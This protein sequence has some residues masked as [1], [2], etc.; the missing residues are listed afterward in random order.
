MF[1]ELLW[2]NDKKFFEAV[3]CMWLVHGSCMMH[4]ER[5]VLKISKLPGRALDVKSILEDT[6]QAKS[7]LW[8]TFVQLSLK[9]LKSLF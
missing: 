7:I 2:K 6:F 9:V 1:D 4:T 3:F 8:D 5:N